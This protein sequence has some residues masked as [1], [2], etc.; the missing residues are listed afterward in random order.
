MDEFIRQ[1]NIQHYRQLLAQTTDETQ[2][3]MLLRLLAEEEAKRVNQG[4]VPK[5]S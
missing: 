5:A 3:K 1:L 2:R 4:T